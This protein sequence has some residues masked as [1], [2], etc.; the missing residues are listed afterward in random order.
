MEV[1]SDMVFFPEALEAVFQGEI[2]GFWRTGRLS[3][4]GWDES[5]KGAL[6]S[7]D[8]EAPAGTSLLLSVHLTGRDSM[9]LMGHLEW[10]RPAPEQ[11]FYE[12]YFVFDNLTA[13]DR[14][15]MRTFRQDRPESLAAAAHEKRRFLRVDKS[16]DVEYQVYSNN[17][18]AQGK[19]QMETLDIGGGGVKLRTSQALESNN[20]IYLNIPM[21]KQETFYSM[22]KVVWVRPLDNNHF[23]VGIKFVDLPQG[24]QDRVIR[25]VQAELLERV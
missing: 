8:F 18:W 11:G 9:N 1:G 10:C 17:V 7:A 23:E 16:L 3:V 15:R 2:G 24:E 19:G 20:F 4:A 6:L 21:G 22:G 25:F 14:E 5:G 13:S 12:L